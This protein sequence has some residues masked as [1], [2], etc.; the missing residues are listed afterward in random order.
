[1]IRI[2]SDEHLHLK[3]QSHLVLLVKGP[4]LIYARSFTGFWKALFGLILN[5]PCLDWKP[6]ENGLEFVSISSE[7]DIE[8]QSGC[9]MLKDCIVRRLLIHI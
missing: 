1:M 7:H 6:K 8:Q 5:W 9:K 3:K 2:V 4:I